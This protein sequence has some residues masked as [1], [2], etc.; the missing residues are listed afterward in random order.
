MKF[1][2]Q[3]IWKRFDIL[4]TLDTD[5]NIEISFS[6]DNC[7]SKS[8]MKLAYFEL[9]SLNFL[10]NVISEGYFLCFIKRVWLIQ[11]KL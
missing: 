3:S 1:V 2:V 5:V 9:E 4:Q 8:M 7:V 6:N 10:M 11:P